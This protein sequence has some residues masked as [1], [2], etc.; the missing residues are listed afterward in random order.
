MT[1]IISI[2]SGFYIIETLAGN[3][4]QRSLNSICPEKGEHFKLR[5]NMNRNV[6]SIDRNIRIIAGII[7]LLAGLFTQV[8]TGLR[9][10]FFA[11]A[12]IAFT[13]ATV[14]F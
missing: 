7:F 9:I 14:G 3:I 5:Y 10:G 12:A 6:G 13:T 4:H 2:I 11:V 1:Y 8:S